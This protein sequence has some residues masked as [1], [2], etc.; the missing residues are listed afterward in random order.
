MGGYE[1]GKILSGEQIILGAMFF[2]DGFT[3]AEIADKTQQTQQAVSVK[4]EAVRRKVFMATG[5]NLIRKR[6]ANSR[7][8]RTMSPSRYR[9][10]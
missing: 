1:L 6:L 3:Q 2:F 5:Q 8:M 4:L 7:H 10:L 9:S